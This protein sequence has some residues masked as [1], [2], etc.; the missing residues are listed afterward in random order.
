MPD[1]L[2]QTGKLR[3]FYRAYGGK[4][5][6]RGA[7]EVGELI[8]VIELASAEFDRLDGEIDLGVV[9][10][11]VVCFGLLGSEAVAQLVLIAK[12]WLRNSIR[13]NA[14]D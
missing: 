9:V 3:R 12:V 7:G 1:R 10:A 13:K 6:R 14:E 2:R 4:L 11:F 8:G 5:D